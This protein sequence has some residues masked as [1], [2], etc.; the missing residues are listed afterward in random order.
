MGQMI[1]ARHFEDLTGFRVIGGTAR[2]QAATMALEPGE[3]TGGPD[4]RHPSSDQWL[5]VL[6]GTGR[7]VVNGRRIALEPGALLL[8]GAGEAHQIVNDGA[9][10]LETLNVYAPPAYAN[11]YPHE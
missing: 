8:I 5:L 11:G 4:N 1:D 10:R 6:E 7:A 3:S 9:E 2:S